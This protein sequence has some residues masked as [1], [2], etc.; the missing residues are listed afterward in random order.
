MSADE[1]PS[2]SNKS[3]AGRPSIPTRDKHPADGVVEGTV[4]ETERIV[5]TADVRP[6]VRKESFI[7]R[8]AKTLFGSEPDGVVSYILWDVLIPAAKDTVQDMVTQGI[9]MFLFPDSSGRRG[10]S[11]KKY[12]DDNRGVVSYGN[13]YRNDSNSP[14]WRGGS[15][16]L[17]QPIAQSKRSRSAGP[18]S[19]LQDV[20]FETGGEAQEV[21]SI[22]NEILELYGEVTVADF[23][24]VA[25][26]ES[27][28]QAT[29]NAWGW[30]SVANTT[31]GRSRD[32]YEIN[33][34][35]TQQTER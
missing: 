31:I 24:D 27:H 14:P 35:R 33:F 8:A 22:M 25:G 5:R 17:R 32:G 10:R 26:L 6:K 12:R 19:R 15:R 7:Q 16:Q 30:Q 29:D 21:L 34:P 11:S 23:Y 20:V 3:K 18:K 2:N 9:E 13:L 1:Y 4:V 28:A